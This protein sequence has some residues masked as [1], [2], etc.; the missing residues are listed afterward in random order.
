MERG[1]GRG[2]ETF[3][4]QATS[5]RLQASGIGQHRDD[6]QE[7]CEER[8]RNDGSETRRGPGRR[9]GSL[10]SALHKGQ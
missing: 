5:H 9:Q 6:D 2:D 3:K 7:R 1:E 8:E 10:T 4:L